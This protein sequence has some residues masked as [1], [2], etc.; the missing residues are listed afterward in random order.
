MWG[1][2]AGAGGSF[3]MD[4]LFLVFPLGSATVWGWACP[5]PHPEKLRITVYL[6][7]QAGS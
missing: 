2:A 3:S 4:K 5:A 7:K 1:F 6:D